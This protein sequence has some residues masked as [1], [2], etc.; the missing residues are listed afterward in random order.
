LIHVD[1]FTKDQLPIDD[2]SV[3]F[4]ICK[5]VFEHLIDPLFLVNEISRILKPGGYLLI[6]VPNHFPIIGRLKFLITNNIDT[7]SYFPGCSRHEFPHIRFFTLS[8]M[9]N[10]L[11]LS[12][13]SIVDNMSFFFFKLPIFHRFIPIQIK[14]LLTRMSTDNF[15]EGITLL[16]QKR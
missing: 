7:F 1:D 10:L 15:S 8:S 12:G 5:D 6:H 9:K 14:K 3:D 4:V 11:D 16:A 2:A 13:F